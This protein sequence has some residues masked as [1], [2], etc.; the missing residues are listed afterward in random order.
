MNTTKIIESIS[1]R[2][3]KEILSKYKSKIKV[4]SHALDHLSDLQRKLCQKPPI[5]DGWHVL[6]S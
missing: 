5:K 3:F 6:L 2:R 1:I 4:G